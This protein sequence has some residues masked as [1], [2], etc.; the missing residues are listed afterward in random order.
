MSPALRGFHTGPHELRRH[1]GC[2]LALGLAWIILR[3]IAVGP[4][5][6]A[7]LVSVF[8]LGGLLRVGGV[9]QLVQAVRTRGWGGFFLPLLTGRLSGIVGVLTVGPPAVRALALT[10]VLASFFL[11]AGVFRIIAAV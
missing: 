4:A 9:I 6:L 10:L 7:T 5:L 2:Y 11:V 1:W 8:V 3:T